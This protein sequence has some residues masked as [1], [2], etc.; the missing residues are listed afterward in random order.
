MNGRSIQMDPKLIK[1]RRLAAR[2]WELQPKQGPRK[3]VTRAVKVAHSKQLE[4]LLKIGKLGFG[5][6][7]EFVTR[8]R[9]DTTP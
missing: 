1:A 4:I 7:F 2:F 5:D 8:Y 6:A 3:K 9:G